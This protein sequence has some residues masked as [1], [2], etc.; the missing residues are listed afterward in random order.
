MKGRL[1]KNLNN[2]KWDTIKSQLA[3]HCNKRKKVS[4][5]LNE[6]FRH[7]IYFQK[8]NKYSNM[9]PEQWIKEEHTKETG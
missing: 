3:E 1:L 4:Q 9:T 7:V 2:V 8:S 5:I 6:K